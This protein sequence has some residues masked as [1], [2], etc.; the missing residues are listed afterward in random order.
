MKE[1]R[2]PIFIAIGLVILAIMGLGGWLILRR[3]IPT[4][5]PADLEEVLGVSGEETAVFFN[6]ELQEVKGITRDGQ[7]Y[8]P[9]QWVNLQ[10][11]EKFY[12]DDTERLLFTRIQGLQAAQ[13]LPSFLKKGM[14]SIY[15]WA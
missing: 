10:V 9:L 7:I 15:P 1:K 3:M 11:N 4:K 12:W 6:E 8:L 14:R 2:I 5:E 13:A